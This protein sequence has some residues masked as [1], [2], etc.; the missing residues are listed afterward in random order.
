M[1]QRCAEIGVIAHAAGI[2]RATRLVAHGAAV[3]VVRQ[4][5]EEGVAL[6]GA[7]GAVA[8]AVQRLRQAPRAA[9]TIPELA[10]AAAPVLTR[11]ALAV[12]VG[13]A[14][15]SRRARAAGSTAIDV[16]LACV[17]QPVSAAEADAVN[18]RDTVAID[19]G[20]ARL[21]DVAAIASRVTAAAVDVALGAVEGA[22]LAGVRSANAR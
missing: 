22:V 17:A 12:P 20:I 18:A 14:E 10:A 4:A 11:A 7:V 13:A 1:N 2:V 21:P 9:R 16:A 5:V 6:S 8:A 19:I 3:G 15:S